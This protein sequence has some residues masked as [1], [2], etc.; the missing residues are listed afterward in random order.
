MT[1]TTTSVD[2]VLVRRRRRVESSAILARTSGLLATSFTTLGW[3][4]RPPDVAYTSELVTGGIIAICLM[5]VAVAVSGY[6]LRCA[7]RTVYGPLQ[8]VGVALDC[9]VITTMVV[10]STA[11]AGTTSWPMMVIP[12]LLAS[13]LRQTRGAISVW[14]LAVACYGMG[15]LLLRGQPPADLAM[16]ACLLLIIGIAA[17]TQSSAFARQLEELHAARAALSHQASHDALTGL[18]NRSLL[19]ERAAGYAGERLAVLVLDLNHFKRVNDNMG[20]A[21]GDE[22]LRVAAQRIVECVGPRDVASRVGGDEFIVLLVDTTAEQAAQ[23]ADRIRTALAQPVDLGGIAVPVHVSI[24]IAHRGPGSATDV[25]TLT[26]QADLAMYADKSARRRAPV[27]PQ[28]ATSGAVSA[29]R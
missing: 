4:R 22:L 16:A 5:L 11:L 3:A 20:H 19:A 17:G 15:P 7:G 27:P 2:D 10:F 21:A 25:E 13:Y 26:G 14:L 28:D 24:G 1:A 23:V 6:A 18:A 8:K 9:G 12:I 29:A